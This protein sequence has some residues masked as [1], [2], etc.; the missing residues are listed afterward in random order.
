MRRTRDDAAASVA[1]PGQGSRSTLGPGR[2]TLRR[3]ISRPRKKGAAVITVYGVY[4][5]GRGLRGQPLNISVRLQL[6]W[7][8]QD[9]SPAG[10]SPLVNDDA[11]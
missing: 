7:T 1:P 5:P 6:G 8:V 4:Q 10:L 11:Y 2:I 3:L 9:S